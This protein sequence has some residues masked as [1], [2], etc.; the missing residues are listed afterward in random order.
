MKIVAAKQFIHSRSG[1]FLV[2]LWELPTRPAFVVSFRIWLDYREAD[3]VGQALEM[4]HK[5]CAMCE[6]TEQALRIS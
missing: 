3:D 5:I 1:V 2:V 4:P 6:W